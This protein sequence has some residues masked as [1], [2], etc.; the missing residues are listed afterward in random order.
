MAE[1][2]NIGIGS[3]A[4]S[5]G[6]PRLTG[7]SS[8]IDTEALVEAAYQAKRFPAVRLERKITQNDAKLAAYD[9]MKT[10]L[11][12]LKSSLNALR[13]PPGLLGAKDN[14]FEVK[15][16]FYASPDVAN[17]GQYM[18]ITLDNRAEIGTYEIEIEQLATVNKLSATSVSGRDQTLADAWS[19]LGAPFSGTLDVGLA[20]GDKASIAIDGTMKIGDLKAAINAKSATTGVT[21]SVLQM[22]DSD[23]RLVLTGKETGKAIEITD[24]SGIAGGFATNELQPAK[25]AKLVVDG[26]PVT[27]TSNQIDDLIQG[28]TINLYNAKDDAKITVTVEPDLGGVKEKLT[29]TVDAYNA[30]REFADRHSVITPDGAVNEESILFG[31]RT[32]RSAVQGITSIFGGAVDGLAADKASTLRGVGVKLAEGN[33]LMIDGAALDNAL[34][35]KLDEV[36]D[37]LE[38]GFTADSEELDVFSRTNGLTDTNFRVEITDADGDGVPEGATADGVALDVSGATIKGAAGTAYEGLE[39]IWIGSG[40]AS[41]DVTATQGLADRAFN[42][43]DEVLDKVDGSIAGAVGDLEGRNTDYQSQM[44]RIEARATEERER[45]IQRF[46]QMETAMSLAQTM[47]DQIRAQMDAWAGG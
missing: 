22:S 3:I 41:I 2:T 44:E 11:S 26:V 24:N 46:T 21:A 16:A 27:R 9:E 28:A 43:L 38:F 13:N 15:Q 12:D 7:S 37:V 40:S 18:G 4:T 32:L 47:M 29:A 25:A 14:A 17:P 23:F 20:G 30:F 34:L 39:L 35:T 19:P 6:R 1:Q 36:R 10:L 8:K 33:R 31:D 5:S 45:L 42:Y